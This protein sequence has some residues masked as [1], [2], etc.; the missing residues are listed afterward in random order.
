M[1]VELY[2]Y[3]FLLR[4]KKKGKEDMNG[5]LFLNQSPG[6]EEEGEKKE[7]MNRS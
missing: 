4:K 3:Y 1:S 2:F 5:M 6:L 7:N